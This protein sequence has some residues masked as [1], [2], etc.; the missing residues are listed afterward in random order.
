[1]N[2]PNKNILVYA[3]GRIEELKQDLVGASFIKAEMVDGEFWEREFDVQCAMNIRDGE[4]APYSM[5]ALEV[6]FRRKYTTEEWEAFQA[7][8]ANDRH[9]RVM[10]GLQLAAE[11]E[12]QDTDD[13][14]RSE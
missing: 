13:S 8:Q 4:R 7:K 2:K 9:R 10:R 5:V 12:A 6:G 1:M 3:D 11:E 14:P